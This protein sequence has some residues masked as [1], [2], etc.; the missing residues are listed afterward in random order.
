MKALILGGANGVG[1]LNLVDNFA[2]HP[3]S[4]PDSLHV[5]QLILQPGSTLNLVNTTLYYGSET[6]LG[7]T[8]TLEGNSQ[9][10]QVVTPEPGS[11][12]LLGVGAVGLLRRRAR[13]R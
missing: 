7:G 6:N 13:R 11:M 9:L 5:D 12:M 3:G 4:G 2:N 10:I 8:I 1:H